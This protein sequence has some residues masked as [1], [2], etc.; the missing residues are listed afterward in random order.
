MFNKKVFMR[1][2]G[3]YFIYFSFILM[4]RAIGPYLLLPTKYDTLLFWPAGIFGCFLIVIDFII[5]F[6]EK[7]LR[8][9][10]WLLY[11]FLGAMLI[12]SLMNLEYGYSQNIKLLMWQAIFFFIVYQF[13]KDYGANFFFKLFGWLISIVWFINNTISLYMFIIQYGVKIPIQYKYY[14]VRL[15]WLG[16]RLFGIYTDPNFGAVI[17]FVV[18]LISIY[19]LI[20]KTSMHLLL[21]TF[22]ILNITI[23]F[24][25][26]ALSGSRTTLV[27]MLIVTF[28]FAFFSFFSSKYLK[29]KIIYKWI[30]SF[31]IGCVSMLGVYTLNYVTA[32]G[33]AYVPTITHLKNVNDPNKSNNSNQKV[34]PKEKVNLDR[35]DTEGG[36]ISNL[37][38]QLWA[39]AV[40]I[41]KSNP[42]SGGSPG[43]YIQYAHDKLPHTFMGKDNLTAHSFIFLI[44]AATGGLG[45]ITFFCFF[46]IQCYK[47]LRYCFTRNDLVKDEVF[48]DILIMLTIVVSALFITELVLVSTIGSFVFWSHLGKIQKKISE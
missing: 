5:G 47:T 10:D 12:S 18:I 21:K 44:M 29:N 41:F 16:N 1:I 27:C 39:S 20:T 37:R 38:F 40:E 7:K 46:F 8:K 11:S 9:Y 3:C 28:V 43:Y 45:L 13:G 24:S 42:M 2:K 48:F 34:P 25:F 19:Y 6:R 30:V 17:S 33:W 22:I 14:P 36:D 32:N 26:I 31:L 4:L 23:Q 35:P 15:G